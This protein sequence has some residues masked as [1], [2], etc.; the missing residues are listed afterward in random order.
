MFGKKIKAVAAVTFLSCMITMT[1]QEHVL[2]GSSDIGKAAMFS[3]KRSDIDKASYL[4]FGRLYPFSAEGAEKGMYYF[5]TTEKKSYYRVKA[6]MGAAGACHVELYDETGSSL[7]AQTDLE[8]MGYER[9]SLEPSSTYYLRVS[10]KGGVSGEIVVSEITDDH[11]DTA[12]EALLAS[13]NKEYSVTS[14]CSMDVDYLKFT[15]DAQDTS[16][17]LSIDPASGSTGEYEVLDETGNLVEGCSGTTE[18]DAKLSKKLPVE[19]G[20]TYYVKISSSETGRQVLASIKQ[21]VNKYKITYH[22]NG[23]TNHK[24]NKTSYTATQNLTLKNPTRKGYL[25][26]GW[27]TAS[28]L[29]RRFPQFRGVQRVITIFMQSGRR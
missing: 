21:T 25:F 16:Y 20:K 27:Y 19:P 2:A 23:G 10:G 29:A 28:N 8:N 22:L 9:F 1:G 13:F 14:E 3:V 15:T 12:E 11:P 24:D 7:V 17:T 26:E 6:L 4:G 5:T 18:Q